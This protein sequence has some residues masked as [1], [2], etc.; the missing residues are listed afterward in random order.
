MTAILTKTKDIYFMTR[1]FIRMLR[2]KDYFHLP[3][4]LGDYFTNDKA[5]F[6]DMKGKAFWDGP[7]EE[8][9]PTLRVPSLGVRTFFP[10]MIIQYGIGSHDKFVLSGDR[11]YLRQIEA[12]FSWMQRHIQDDGSYNNCF[13][14]LEPEMNYYSSCSGMTQGLAISFLVR[15][16]RNDLEIK[17]D[18][19]KVKSLIDRVY[20]SLIRPVEQGGGTLYNGDHICICEYPRKDRYIVLNGWVFGVFGLIDYARWQSRKGGAEQILKRTLISLV[21]DLPSYSFKNS[22]WTYYDNKGRVCSPIYQSLHIHL[23]DAL[24]RLTGKNEFRDFFVWCR[25]GYNMRNRC[26][27]TIAKIWEK[28]SDR[29]RYGTA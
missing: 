8:E 23:F 21:K 24:W 11:R 14:M 16:L 20:T 6:N 27:Y 26:Y 5:Y 12:V 25:H 29:Y 28:L 2:G 1:D 9:V 13:E 17:L 7:L 4:N 3:E 18:I 15:L 22:G 19:C 10:S